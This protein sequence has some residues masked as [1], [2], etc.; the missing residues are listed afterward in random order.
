MR[1]VLWLALF[2]TMTPAWAENCPANH[3]KDTSALIQLEQAWAKALERHDVDTVACIL[4]PGFQDA[5]PEGQLHS[6]EEVLAAIPKRRPGVNQLSELDP[7]LYGD[8]GYIRGLAT[9]LDETGQVKAK[10]RF[11]DIFV[12]RDGR[13]MAVAGQESLVSNAK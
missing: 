13:W 9:L 3:T 1:N 12:Y 10:V 8:V 5:D 2:A 6:R 7:H 4:G 11:T